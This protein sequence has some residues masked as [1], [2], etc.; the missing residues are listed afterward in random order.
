MCKIIQKNLEFI[1]SSF[2]LKMKKTTAFAGR[3]IQLFSKA[4]A[5]ISCSSLEK[6]FKKAVAYFT[7]HPTPSGEKMAKIYTRE[8]PQLAVCFKESVPVIQII[9]PGLV[10]RIKEAEDFYQKEKKA[11]L[12][13]RR[14]KSVETI[15]LIKS[16]LLT[17]K[18]MFDEPNIQSKFSSEELSSFFSEIQKIENFL[19]AEAKILKIELN[20]E[21]ID[22][23]S[24][25]LN[26]HIMGIFG[27][28]NIFFKYFTKMAIALEKDP[29][30]K[31]IFQKVAKAFV[32]QV[33]KEQK[34]F[35]TPSSDPYLKDLFINSQK[36]LKLLQDLKHQQ[37]TS[38]PN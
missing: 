19:A 2:S 15:G 13:I 35:K 25:D 9:N 32:V 7:E 37:Q 6:L 3:L 1:H 20:E 4:M 33:N 8:A 36:A 5:A 16:H 31:K 29:A 22:L 23:N 10:N 12:S 28:V 21:S 18:L 17:I 27:E 26:D 34:K 11:F 38:A 14:F 30:E 24:Q